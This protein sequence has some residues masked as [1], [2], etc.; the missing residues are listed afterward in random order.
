[1]FLTIDI[2]NTRPKAALFDA[3]EMVRCGLFDDSFPISDVDAVAVC[4]TAPYPHL[5]DLLPHGVPVHRLDSSTPLPVTIHYNTPGTLGPDRMAAV[6]AAHYLYQGQGCLIVDAGTCVTIDYLSPQGVF[7]GGLIM[8]GLAM[9]FKALHTFTAKLP[10]I[11]CDSERLRSSAQQ[12]L[13]DS[14][15]Q[16]ITSGVVNGMCG[17]VGGL[18]ADICATHIVHRLLFTGGDAQWLA[19]TLYA[20][21]LRPTYLPYLTLIGLNAIFGRK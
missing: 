19:D 11:E 2:G 16:C 3:D 17:E 6:C 4:A 13:G 18:V 15:T 9:R 5:E 20:C 8:P 10:L 1:M 12:L 7:E 14:T 21:P